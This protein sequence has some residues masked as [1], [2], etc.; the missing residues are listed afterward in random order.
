MKCPLNQMPIWS[1]FTITGGVIVNEID[2]C[3]A[4]TIFIADRALSNPIVS[5]NGREKVS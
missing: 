5:L 1:Q 4:R 2:D 3:Y